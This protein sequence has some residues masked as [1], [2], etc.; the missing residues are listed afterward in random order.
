M[1]VFPRHFEAVLP[2]AFDIYTPQMPRAFLADANRSV[3]FS[4]GQLF[5]FFLLILASQ[6]RGRLAFFNS[7]PFPQLTV[8]PTDRWTLRL[9]FVHQA[10]GATQRYSYAY[11]RPSTNNASVRILGSFNS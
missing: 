8:R 9:M 6:F 1:S 4:H 10:V 7:R 3:V 11:R 2:T 5:S